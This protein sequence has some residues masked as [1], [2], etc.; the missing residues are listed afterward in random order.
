MANNIKIELQI[1]N[2]NS[3]SHDIWTTTRASITYV[4]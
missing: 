4:V 2:L 3:W 1:Q